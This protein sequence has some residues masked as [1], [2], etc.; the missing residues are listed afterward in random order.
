MSVSRYPNWLVPFF[1]AIIAIYLGTGC[2]SENPSPPTETSNIE[3][4]QPTTTPIPFGLSRENPLNGLETIALKNWEVHVLDIVRG[5]G[6]WNRL[7]EANQFNASPPDGWSYILVQY[8][9]RRKGDSQIENSLGLHLTGSASILYYSFNTTA[10]PPDP[11][12]DTY[13]F[14]G[15]MSRGWEAYLIKDDESDLMLVIDDLSDYEEPEYFARLDE[16]ATLTVPATLAEIE[17]TA[18]GRELDDP[19]P[20]GQ[21]ATSEEWQVVVQN[22]QQGE[23][24]A[25]RVQEL[26]RYNA[27]PADG[28][29]YL[30]AKVWVRYIGS[31]PSGA[32]VSNSAFTVVNRDNEQFSPVWVSGLE[33]RFPYVKLFPGGEYDGWLAFLVNSNDASINLLFKSAYADDENRRYLSLQPSGR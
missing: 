30:L 13:L 31:N 27:L 5:T 16:D 25:E 21:I 33:P 23:V 28:Q 29:S 7:Q 22:V 20:F 26:S 17:A 10:V 2:Q 4:L 9:L 6:A 3:Q 32:L 15:E 1:L 8:E 11:I 14:G 19:L 24:A 18:V 12:L